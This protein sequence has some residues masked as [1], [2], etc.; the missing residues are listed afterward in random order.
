M[1]VQKMEKEKITISDNLIQ[2]LCEKAM[3]NDEKLPNVQR[4]LDDAITNFET[5]IKL[6]CFRKYFKQGYE[7]ACQVHG[8]K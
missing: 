7:Y 3:Y 6:A 1:G 4:E 5:A 8:I 2:E